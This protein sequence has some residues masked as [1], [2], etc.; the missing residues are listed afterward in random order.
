MGGG[1]LQHLSQAS[2]SWSPDHI[3]EWTTIS[4]SDESWMDTM[5][6]SGST[7]CGASL[8]INAAVVNSLCSLTLT[9][10][11][12]LVWPGFALCIWLWSSRPGG[13]VRAACCTMGRTCAQWG[14]P[15][16]FAANS[17]RCYCAATRSF[18]F[19]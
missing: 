10:L 2:C 13:W 1:C 16:C 7:R 15:C 18:G 19:G 14:A 3:H 5:S 12:F 6:S 4:M 11:E 8:L 9:K 17:S